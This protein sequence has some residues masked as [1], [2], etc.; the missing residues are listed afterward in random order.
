MQGMSDDLLHSLQQ[1]ILQWSSAM[2]PVDIEVRVNAQNTTQTQALSGFSDG[3]IGEIKGQIGKALA[4]S[5][6]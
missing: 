2:I 6:H 5:K 1:Y 3:G 4:D